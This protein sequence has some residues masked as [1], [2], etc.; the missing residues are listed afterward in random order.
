MFVF[1]HRVKH[2]FF[3]CFKR[4]T[5]RSFDFD[6]ITGRNLQPAIT[7]SQQK[8][9][10]AAAAATAPHSQKRLLRLEGEGPG[11]TIVLI[12]VTELALACNIR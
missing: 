6:F 10:E 12:V 7:A 2:V 5:R 11:V 4:T 1:K 8:T 3:Y 9:P